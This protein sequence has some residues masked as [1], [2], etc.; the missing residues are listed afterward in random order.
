MRAVAAILLALL[1][2]GCLSASFSSGERVDRSSGP[3]TAFEGSVP[4]GDEPGAAATV[5]IDVP[6]NASRL[7]IRLS[8]ANSVNLR[9]SAAGCGSGTTTNTQVS[10]GGT[11]RTTLVCDAPAAGPLT[12][13]VSRDAGTGPVDVLATAQVTTVE[14]SEGK[15]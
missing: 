7:E 3:V 8:A 14:R 2:G 15:A 6:A 5:T 12:L 10:V 4:L 13:T 1:L 9:G 11:Q